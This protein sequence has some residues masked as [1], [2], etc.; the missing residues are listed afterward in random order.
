MKKSMMELSILFLVLGMAMGLSM[1]V[2]GGLFTAVGL[3][4][5][6]VMSALVC[7][8]YNGIRRIERRAE[9]RAR[10]DAQA[11]HA[12]Q[13]YRAGVRLYN[14]YV[15]AAEQRTAPDLRVA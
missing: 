7:R 2:Y 3:A 1:L 14:P 8:L 12:A 6:L 9:R 13:L 15:P 5:E 11:H 10:R 4:A